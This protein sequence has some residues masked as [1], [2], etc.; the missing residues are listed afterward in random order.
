MKEITRVNIALNHP[1]QDSLLPAMMSV[2]KASAVT[3]DHLE[4]IVDTSISDLN[5]LQEILASTYQTAHIAGFRGECFVAF[6]SLADLD[7]LLPGA[8]HFDES[9]E[10]SVKN[11]TREEIEKL[12]KLSIERTQSTPASLLKIKE[13]ARACIGGTFDHIHGGHKIF[14]S[15]GALVTRI[16]LVG[17]TQDFMLAKKKYADMLEPYAKRVFNVQDFLTKFDRSLTLQIYAL[18]DG[19]GPYKQDFDA[20]IVSKETETGGVIINQKRAE[21]D[22]P[23]LNIVVVDLVQDDSEQEKVSS[24]HFRKFMSEM[25]TGDQLNYLKKSWYDSLK[26]IGVEG[27]NLE[28][29]LWRVLILYCQPWRKYHTLRH[30]VDL[31]EKIDKLQDSTAASNAFLKITAFFHDVIYTPRS[32]LN[33]K[34]SS[35]LL[36]EFS[37]TLPGGK[38]TLEVWNQMSDVILATASHELDQYPRLMGNAELRN[39]G[40]TF[41]DIDMS[42]LAADPP[43]YDEYTQQ[44]AFEYS[45]MDKQAF[46]K[47]RSQ[48]LASCIEKGQKIF[49]SA[50]FEHLN[51]V[52]HKNM[53]WEL[54]R[55]TA[56]DHV[57]L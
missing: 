39:L 29:W 16:L 43:A 53:K 22:L 6:S 4:V 27:P 44:I 13:S 1:L 50:A 23:P 14:L 17:I 31:C 11:E 34:K 36:L 7:K 40:Q 24:T 54:Q 33:E 48:F 28:V 10:I 47:G 42:I 55:L 5:L 20:V 32:K 37:A 35:E 15:V 49:K 12:C 3:T 8:W 57:D 9:Q 38:D 52:A 45:F 56:D 2:A 21:A 19:L 41:L 51:D 46:V 25:V 30:I 26:E 18:E